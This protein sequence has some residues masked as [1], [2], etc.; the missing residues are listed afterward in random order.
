MQLVF[1]RYVIIS[2]KSY[3]RPLTEIFCYFCHFPVADDE[4]IH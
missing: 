1:T 2:V 3:W 4:T